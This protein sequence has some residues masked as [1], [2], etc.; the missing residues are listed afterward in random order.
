MPGI[1]TRKT[2]TVGAP[3]DAFALV[4]PARA[5]GTDDLHADVDS[6]LLAEPDDLGARA[7][8]PAHEGLV[9]A[10]RDEVLGRE[11]DGADAVEMARELLE[12]G[13]GERREEV[14]APGTFR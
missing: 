9:G 12:R 6:R 4:F 3:D 13:E 7:P 1:L 8:V 14:D 10:G 11:R 2:T 5:T